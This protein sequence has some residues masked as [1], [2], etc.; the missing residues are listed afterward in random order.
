MNT[1]FNHLSFNVSDAKKSLPFYKELL[2]FLGYSVVSESPDHL[3]MRN[4]PTDVWISETDSKFKA[5]GFHRKSTGINHI[6]FGVKSRAEVDK[7]NNE[8]LKKRKIPAL[9]NSPKAF[10]EYTKDYYAVYFED[11]DRIKIE[12][13]YL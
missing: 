12:V 9:Y 7:F 8:F 6:C 3:G 11:P 1:T 5:K 4:S 2:T 10:P 13:A